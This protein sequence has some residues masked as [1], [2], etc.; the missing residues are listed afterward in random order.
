M[1]RRPREPE[2]AREL[3]ARDVEA[4]RVRRDGHV[5]GARDAARLL[6]LRGLA[7][8]DEEGLCGGGGG[9]GEG[10]DLSGGG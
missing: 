6:Q 8:V 4:V 5:H 2:A 9:G 3:G 7:D 1:A 10:L